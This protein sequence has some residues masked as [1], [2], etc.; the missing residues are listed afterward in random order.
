M[1]P[2]TRRT[3]AERIAHCKKKGV[4]P[5]EHCCLDMAWFAS[6]P[7]EWEVEGPNPVIQWV[8]EWGEYRLY[9]SKGGHTSTQLYYCPWCGR[10]LPQS[11]KGLA[12]V[13]TF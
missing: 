4:D 1:E 5:A 12:V 11:K 2:V 13:S 9:P 6:D 8:R 10:R 3:D 7:I